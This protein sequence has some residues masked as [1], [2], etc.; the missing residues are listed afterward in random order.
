MK[1]TSKD[2]ASDKIIVAFDIN[3]RERFLDL[4]KELEGKASYIKIGM[5]C[6]YSL[7]PEVLT[8]AKAKGFKVFLDLKLHDI[9]NTVRRSVYSLARHGADMLNVHALGGL[10]MMKA[11]KLGLEEAKRD[12]NLQ[13]SPKLIAVTHLTSLDQNA[14]SQ[15]LGIKRNLE[16]SVFDLAR[17]AKEAGLDGVVSSAQETKIIKKACG[18]DFLTITPGI[19]IADNEKD[20]Q[21]RVMTPQSAILAGSDYLVMGRSITNTDSPAQI[22]EN[23]LKQIESL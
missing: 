2:H 15:E 3:S 6:Y 21:K 22:F 10:E 16:D 1:Y 5:E 11:A 19:R 7:G 20:D 17:L 23:I 12:F 8:L 4:A 13:S 14:L 18:T 9:P